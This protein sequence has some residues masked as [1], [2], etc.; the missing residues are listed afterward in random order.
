MEDGQ[1]IDLRVWLK[2]TVLSSDIK[3]RIK[4]NND[5]NIKSAPP[6]GR[7]VVEGNV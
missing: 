2:L 7:D 4:T 5:T 1:V 3:Y 6:V